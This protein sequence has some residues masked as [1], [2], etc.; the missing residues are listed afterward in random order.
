MRTLVAAAALAAMSALATPAAFA[1]T[2]ELNDA[3]AESADVSAPREAWWTVMNDPTL[4]RLV[5]EA[6][7]KNPGLAAARDAVREQRAT[8]SAALSPALPSVSVDLAATRTDVDPE[9]ERESFAGASGASGAAAASAFSSSVPYSTESGSAYLAARWNVDV[10]GS[11]IRNSAALGRAADAALETRDE[12]AASTALAVALAWYDLLAARMQAGAIETQ[13]TANEQMLEL[14]QLR[15]ERAAG[16]GLDVLQQRQQLAATA[17]QR[18]AARA[19]VV[20]AEAVLV[21]LLG[22]A[23]DHA[24]G[25]DALPEPPPAPEYGAP[26]DLLDNRPD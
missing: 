14:V 20:E 3:A 12:R 17:T 23:I 24:P 16:T 11:T 18:P 9:G 13:I 15:F 6:L 8:A 7:A 2:A 21:E 25:A 22:G 19:R 1:Q 10:F 4:D 5:R 26:D